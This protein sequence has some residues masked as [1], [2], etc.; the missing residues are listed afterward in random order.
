MRHDNPFQGKLLQLDAD[1]ASFD[2][3]ID[4]LDLDSKCAGPQI[5]NYRYISPRGTGKSLLLES[6]FSPAKCQELAQE[7]KKLVCIC[8]FSGDE[9]RTDADVFVRLIEAVKDSLNNLDLDSPEYKTLSESL[10]Q[11]QL[12]YPDYRS[13]PNKGEELLK[14]IL[15][16]LRSKRYYVTLVLD[17]F[18][19]LACAGN[20][21]DATFSKMAAIGQ[22]KLISYIVASDYDDDVGSETYYI[23]RFSRIFSG[24][25]THLEGITSKAGQKAVMELIRKKLSRYEDIVFTDAELRTLIELTGGIPG[26][27]QA[28]LRDVFEIKRESNAE[29]NTQQLSDYALSACGSLLSKWVQYF[30]DA[31]WETMAAVIEEV[32]E[33]AIS[34][35]LAQ[36]MDQRNSLTNA[37]LIY[38]DIRRQE[39]DTICPIFTAYVQA[40][41]PR[42]RKNVAVASDKDAPRI[43]NHYHFENGAKYVQG[44]DNSQTLV[45][46]NVQIQNGLTVSDVL[47]ILGDEQGDTRELF[48]ARLSAQLRKMLP[49]EGVQIP[50][51]D[52]FTSAEEY[53]QEYDQAFD[54]FSSKII[55]DVE[56]DEDQDLAVT[57]AEL[58]TL[59][60]RFAD[61]R[62]RCR[63]ELTDEMLASQ[64][65]RCQFYL[66]LSVIV[67]DALE[68]PGIQMEDYSP[69]LV[70]YAKALEQSL[71]DNLFD[72][73]HREPSLSVYDTRARMDAP[74]S[75]ETFARFDM[76]HTYIGN[77]QFMMSHKKDYLANL[78]VRNQIS[79]VYLPEDE[80]DWTAWW[81]KLSQ[82]VNG[83]REIRNATDHA[84]ETSP[85]RDDLNDMCKLL[86]GTPTSTGIIPRVA[87]G[88]R[89]YLL[90]YPPEISF[91]VTQK[92]LN[93]TCQMRCTMVK[94][95]GG[96]KGVLCDGGYPVN[97]SPNRVNS[98]RVA[99]NAQSVDLVEKI[100]TI[101]VLESNSQNNQTYFGAQIISMDC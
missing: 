9:M 46:E 14:E 41:L 36:D 61:A 51:R 34:K 48:A 95:N 76:S 22:R 68:L 24:S 90:M 45:A 38:K 5:L 74:N 4:L 43:E 39:Y 13:D 18:H 47:R 55:S 69:Q 3:E 30:D 62:R 87:V 63:G 27:L 21:A 93:Q 84:N 50:P 71:R 77:Y 83:A 65:E 78:C 10:K 20:L 32:T 49:A 100:L 79:T 6:Y 35:R 91:A 59:D 57:A 11:K 42:R 98:F 80:Q 70:L 73:F 40:E 81:N 53:S 26:L 15:N 67:E 96:I 56:V 17:E 52:N 75:L 82:D 7:Q 54:E 29:L 1:L 28:A 31:R 16:Y 64:S 33:A 12:A 88:K 19:Q 2:R 86:F 8:Q 85:G 94:T 89:L 101:K 60:A 23:S 92:F 25:T 44:D 72:L 37:G 99:N 97:I 66:K 58:Q